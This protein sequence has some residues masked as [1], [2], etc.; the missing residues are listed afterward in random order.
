MT[1]EFRELLEQVAK[2]NHTTVEEVY[3]EM[4]IAIDAGFDNPDPEICSI[5]DSHGEEGVVYTLKRG[6][7]L[8][9]EFKR[10]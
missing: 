4:Q 2:K 9:K 8:E 6:E 3:K 1:K 7:K 5:N 10:V